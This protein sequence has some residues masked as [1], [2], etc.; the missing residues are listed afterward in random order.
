MDTATTDKDRFVGV[1]F[2]IFITALLGSV[3]LAN[4]VATWRDGTAALVWPSLLLFAAHIGLYWVNLRQFTGKRWRLFYYAAQATLIV[5]LAT[6]PYGIDSNATLAASLT[7]TQVGEALG[8]WGNTRRALWLGLFYFGLLSML[9]SLSV[10]RD[11]LLLSAA[12][13]MLNGNFIV[14]L[15][16]LYNQQLAERQKAEELTETLESANAQLAAYAAQNA[17]LTLQ[18]ERQ[19]MARE[20]HDTLAQGVAGLVLQLEAVKAHLAAGRDERA[21]EIVEQALGRAR[22]TLAASRAAIDDLRATTTDLAAAMRERAERFSQATGILC[23]VDVATDAGDE[24]PNVTLEHVLAVLGEALANVARHAAATQATVRLAREDGALLLTVSDDGCGFDPAQTPGAG[25]YGLLGMRERARLMGGS[26]SV[27]SA[28][29]R[30][31]CVQLVA[32]A[33]V[34]TG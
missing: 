33:M 30:G 11:K 4:A 28:P 5:I 12:G 19:R 25:H 18:A 13:I 34:S 27:H 32:P 8:L 31:T 16:V 10:A 21:A 14:L 2:Y 3:A 15:M 1:P 20:L 29:E 24:L 6:L 9:L 23:T 17:A 26:L 7:I 22:T